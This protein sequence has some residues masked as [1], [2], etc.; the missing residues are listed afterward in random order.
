MSKVK[1]DYDIE[2]DAWSWVLIAKDKNVWGLSW[3]DQIPHI[4]DDL[5]AKIEKASF[6]RAV[7]IVKQEIETDPRRA[8]KTKVMQSEME[9]LEKSWRLVE[10]KYFQ[11][12]SEITQEPIYTE[13]FGCFFTTGFMCPYNIKENWFMVSLWHAVPFSIT[14]VCHELLHLQFLHYYKNYLKKNGLNNDQIETLKE[15]LTFLLNEP[16]LR[17]IILSE[18]HGY[19]EHQKLRKRLKEIWDKEK[20]FKKFLDRV[21]KEVGVN[22]KV[23]AA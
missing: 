7:K 20:D 23:H 9:A 12:L 18:D 17:S 10:K 3:R 19:P 6:S 4:S 15:A 11:I 13:N 22:S 5:L 14:T 21:I 8:Y 2:K 16:E 1:F